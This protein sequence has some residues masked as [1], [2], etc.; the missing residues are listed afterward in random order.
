VWTSYFGVSQIILRIAVNEKLPAA[1][2][3][4][5][6]ITQD[7]KTFTLRH[8]RCE[9]VHSHLT[10][11][12]NSG[13]RD[14]SRNSARSNLLGKKAKKGF[15]GYPVATVAL[16]GPDNKRASKIALGIVLR[17]GAEPLMERFFSDEDIR[18]DAEVQEQILK[19]I[20]NHGAKSVVLTDGIIGCPHEEGIDYPEGQSCPT[21]PF[22]AGRDRFTHERVH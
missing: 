11:I 19:S 14:M 4:H 10:K 6:R 8:M 20:Q 21:C 2:A 12:D 18:Y 3:A 17:E 9:G 22:W 5:A 1:H 16:Y 13:E 7:M 15:R